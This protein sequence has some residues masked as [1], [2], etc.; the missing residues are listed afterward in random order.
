MRCG[1]YPATL[2]STQVVSVAGGETRAGILNPAQALEQQTGSHQQNETQRHLHQHQARSHQ[3]S[4][5]STHHAARFGL[6]RGSEIDLA[7][8][9][10][11]NQPEQQ[12]GDQANAGAQGEHAPIDFARQIHPPA[13]ARREQQHEQVAAP[14]RQQESA[15]RGERRE[16]HSFGEKLLQQPAASGADRQPDRHLMPAPEGPDQQQI[17][18]V[19]AR[20]EEHRN[21]HGER[22][23]KRREQR[24]A[25]C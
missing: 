2:K 4:P 1:S 3:P 23:S 16:N 20:D 11:G 13:A 9:H 18:D 7:G 24:A 19:R 22:D 14:V 5:A 12:R 8:L 17:A 6:Q 15:G 25:R 21:H 10:G